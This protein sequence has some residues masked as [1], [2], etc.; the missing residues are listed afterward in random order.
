LPGWCTGVDLLV[1]DTEADITAA[2][3]RGGQA[4]RR[5]RAAA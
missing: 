3:E 5:R 2:I 4:T 1:R